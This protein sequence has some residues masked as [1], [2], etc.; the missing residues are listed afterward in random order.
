MGLIFEN[1][2]SVCDTADVF[3]S[4][5]LK[6]YYRSRPEYHKTDFESNIPT[7]M[8]G[9]RVF[10]VRLLVVYLTFY[11]LILICDKIFV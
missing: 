1:T 5:M 9:W 11:R 8:D 4:E 3:H 7:T 2:K 6:Q 10:L